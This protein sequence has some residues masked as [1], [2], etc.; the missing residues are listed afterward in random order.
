MKSQQLLFTRMVGQQEEAADSCVILK[1]GRFLGSGECLG[2]C[3]AEE[4]DQCVLTGRLFRF[5]IIWCS[6]IHVLPLSPPG[7]FLTDVR[8]FFP[9]L[10]SWFRLFYLEQ[11]I[12]KLF[13]PKAEYSLSFFL[14]S[15]SRW[16]AITQRVFAL[17]TK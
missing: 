15:F 6:C 2:C 8:N 14:F 5:P 11:I 17:F 3:W 1:Y 4:G 16:S 12:L 9:I 7:Y 13:F 10:I